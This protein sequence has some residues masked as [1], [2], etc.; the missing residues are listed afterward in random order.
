LFAGLSEAPYYDFH[1]LGGKINE[2]YP[3]RSIG[4]LEVGI[5][6]TSILAETGQNNE[7]S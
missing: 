2:H 3:L 1:F 4:D 7:Y 6:I 5:K